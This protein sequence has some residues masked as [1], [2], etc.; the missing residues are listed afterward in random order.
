MNGVY[1]KLINKIPPHEVYIEPYL[2]SGAIMRHKRPAKKNIA[3]DLDGSNLINSFGFPIQ[4]LESDAIQF[5]EDYSFDG[6][7]F[8]YLDPPYLKETRK[9][10]NKYIYEC[11]EKHHEKLIEVIKKMPC[12]VMISG[13]MSDLYRSELGSWATMAYITRDRS[14]DEVQENVWMNYPDPISLHDY[15]FVGSD[16]RERERIKR[17]HE[18]LK[19]KIISLPGYE[20]E[21]LLKELIDQIYGADLAGVIK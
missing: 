3:L 4:F 13:Y 17:K 18:R 14:G 21:H 16:F 9:S 1:Q 2:G 6:S 19:N 8:V 10:R 5:L 15:R 12:S 20:R 7:E 11:D